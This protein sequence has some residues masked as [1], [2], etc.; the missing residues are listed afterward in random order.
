MIDSREANDDEPSDDLLLTNIIDISMSDG[1]QP[2]K[3]IDVLLPVQNEKE[4]EDVCI[5]TTSKQYP[6]TADDWEVIKA[7]WDA[8]A[9]GT[10]FKIGHFS[11]YV[12][13]FDI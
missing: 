6:E 10:R 13:L 3:D 7:E 5:L 2:K 8:N 12:K 4:G 1:K 11:M 9:N